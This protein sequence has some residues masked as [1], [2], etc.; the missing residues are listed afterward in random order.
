MVWW[1][2]F[3]LIVISIGFCEFLG[4]YI[5]LSKCK[6]PYFRPKLENEYQLKPLRAMVIADT[7]LLGPLKGH[8]LDKIYR[9]WH[10]SRAFQT[11]VYL[12][13]PDVIFFL[14]DLFDEGDMVN[15][16]EFAEFARRFK[17][18]FQTLPSVPVLSAVGNHD[19]GFHYKYICFYKIISTFLT[20]TYNCFLR[21]NHYFLDR[22]GAFFNNTGVEMYTI[23]GNHFVVINSM[24]MENDGCEF[25]DVAITDLQKVARKHL[26]L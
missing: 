12:H 9:E 22:F 13:E 15:H 24:A 18:L 3:G 21:M 4:D 25:C 11:A 23:R 17:S 14:G 26:Q 6:W 10:M 8:W 2:Y 1:N 16:Y 20:S 19:V 7:H 5:I